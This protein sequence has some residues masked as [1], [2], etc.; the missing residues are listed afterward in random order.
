MSGACS[1]IGGECRRVVGE[2]IKLVVMGPK[3]PYV[4][5]FSLGTFRFSCEG[6]S[7]YLKKNE[8]DWHSELY[9]G[10]KDWGSPFCMETF[11]PLCFQLSIPLLFFSG[12]PKSCTSWLSLSRQQ[13]LLREWGLHSHW[14]VMGEWKKQGLLNVAHPDF[15]IIPCF[16]FQSCLHLPRYLEPVIPTVTFMYLHTHMHTHIYP[17]HLSSLSSSVM[18]YLLLLQPLSISGVINVLHSIKRVCVFFFS[19][20][21]VLEC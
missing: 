4:M 20:F 1:V 16:S 12:G 6:S 11:N 17:R 19:V 14:I 15:P 3:C 18:C 9:V 5:L 21:L 2:S 7:A 10:K 8:P 13:P